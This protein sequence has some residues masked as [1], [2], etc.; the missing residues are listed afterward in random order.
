MKFLAL[1]VLVLYLFPTTPV[2]SQ[3]TVS[4]TSGIYIVDTTAMMNTLTNI[5]YKFNKV[6]IAGLFMKAT[7]SRRDYS[8]YGL[9]LS[10]NPVYDYNINLSS[11][12][13]RMMEKDGYAIML[14]TTMPLP[15]SSSIDLIFEPGVEYLV[16][17]GEKAQIAAIINLGIY[18]SK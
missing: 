6:G 18:F 17:N 10:Y 4:H 13:M 9:T 1:C 14:S 3:F 7:N 15:I 12:V 5:G 2:F 11:K 8:A 16:L